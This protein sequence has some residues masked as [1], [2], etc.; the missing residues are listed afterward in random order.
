MRI[1]IN[2]AT[3]G[4]SSRAMMR[5]SPMINAATKRNPNHTHGSELFAGS[6]SKTG[7]EVIDKDVYIRLYPFTRD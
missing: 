5:V 7:S 2:V 1:N 4:S 6:S 3:D